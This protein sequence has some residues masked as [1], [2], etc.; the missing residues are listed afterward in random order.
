MLK[1]RNSKR[2]ISFL[3]FSPFLSEIC[4]HILSLCIHDNYTLFRIGYVYNLI[5]D[6]PLLISPPLCSVLVQIVQSGKRAWP[7]KSPSEMMTTRNE[8]C[9]V[10]WLSFLSFAFQQSQICCTGS[11]LKLRP[12]SFL[13]RR[14]L[15][16]QA[17]PLGT[18]IGITQMGVI[19]KIM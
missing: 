16:G 8:S 19:Y 5:P 1:H 13:A 2:S 6:P 9:I 11:S 10:W 14:L 3:I 17:E 18:E 15:A 7:I 4:S 12:S